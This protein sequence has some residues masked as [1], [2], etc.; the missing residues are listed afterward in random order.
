[1]LLPLKAW[2]QGRMRGKVQ[3]SDQ[4]LAESN[5]REMKEIVAEIKRRIAS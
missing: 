2:V 4:M 5:M 1:M 3:L